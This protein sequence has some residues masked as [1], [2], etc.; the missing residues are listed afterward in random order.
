MYLFKDESYLY[1]AFPAGNIFEGFH[2]A[3]TKDNLYF[4]SYRY[5]GTGRS[6]PVKLCPGSLNFM[7]PDQRQA[8]FNY[9]LPALPYSNVRPDK[10][11]SNRLSGRQALT[12]INLSSPELAD[13]PWTAAHYISCEK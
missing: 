1:A 6:F 3:F 7:N 9:R 10:G 4:A 5:D 8:L 13:V 2:E 12:L 11:V